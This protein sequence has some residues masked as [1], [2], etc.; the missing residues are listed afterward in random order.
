MFVVPLHPPGPLRLKPKEALP[1]MISRAGITLV[2]LREIQI[3]CY[4][5]QRNG[6]LSQTVVGVLA[7][8]TDISEGPLLEGT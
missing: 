5:A 8:H 6:S 2:F 3:G 1:A 7:G 4:P